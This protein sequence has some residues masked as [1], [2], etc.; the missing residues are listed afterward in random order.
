MLGRGALR[1][2]QVVERAAR[3]LAAFQILSQRRQQLLGQGDYA[4]LPRARSLG[5]VGHWRMRSIGGVIEPVPALIERSG[6]MRWR[7]WEFATEHYL[8]SRLKEFR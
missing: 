3:Q 8:F 4:D 1:T 6:F 5:R 7:H 2:S